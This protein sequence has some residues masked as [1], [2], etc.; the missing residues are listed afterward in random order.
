MVTNMYPIKFIPLYYPKIWGSRDWKE[1]D[2][3]I[4]QGNIG[5]RWDVACHAKG[6]SIVANGGYK[7][8]RLD[9][10][11]A[12]NADLLLGTQLGSSFP[13]LI[14]LINA[15]DKLSVQVH[16]DDEYALRTE[17]GMGKTEAWYVMDAGQNAKLI[18]GLKE[19]CTR[20]QFVVAIEQGC[21]GKYLHEIPVKKGDA[22][23]IKAGLIHAVCE[24]VMIAE[25]QQN[26]DITY[27]VYDYNRGREL[28]IEKA[29]DVIDFTLT[30]KK[31]TG[32]REVYDGVSKTKLCYSEHFC[33]ELYDVRNCCSEC[34]ERE[35]FYIFTCVNGSG[36]IRYREN[37]AAVALRQGESV[38]IPAS[39]GNY[40]LIGQMQVIKSYVPDKTRPQLK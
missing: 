4:H 32:I 8:M 13:L 27:R 23:F 30:G 24:G 16:P 38:L 29:L 25:I 6:M 9:E 2:H 1:L 7:G 14:K 39:L 28:H 34:S 37:S 33:L 17:G 5:E 40:S 19:H 15:K 10:L 11:I 3:N 18:I 26:S 21:L 35:R 22:F 36:E 20:G 12:R 31:V